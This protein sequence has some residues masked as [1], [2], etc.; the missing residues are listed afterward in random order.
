MNS[1]S[2]GGCQS[3]QWMSQRPA[4]VDGQ[5]RAQKLFGKLDLNSDEGI[6]ST[7]LKSFI[8]AVAEK[9]GTQPVDSDAL[10]T[11]L[12]SDGDGVVSSTEL[13]DNGRA[14]FEQ[15]RQQLVGGAREAPPPQD[16]SKL[17][18]A[19]DSNGD[20]SLSVDEFSAG[21]KQRMEQ[22]G[23]AGGAVQPP[24]DGGFGRF[25]E[26]LLAEYGAESASQAVQGGSLDI[27]A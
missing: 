14:L 27:A 2:M 10:M 26:S 22:G 9:S 12:D 3:A 24:R 1:V 11:S 6:D 25:I 5:D 23:E 16:P 17:F 4:Q 18:S 20:G 8:D 19:L 13:S 15:L 21:M 7:E